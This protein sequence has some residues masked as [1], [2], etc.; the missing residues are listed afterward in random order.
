MSAAEVQRLF[1]VAHDGC[2]ILQADGG[3]RSSRTSWHCPCGQHRN[4][5]RTP[6]LLIRPAKNERYGS[7]I[8]QG[9]SPTCAFHGDPKDVFDAFNVYRILHGLSNA[10]MLLHA[11][12][13]LGLPEH[14]PATQRDDTGQPDHHA[15]RR[16]V[17]PAETPAASP[18]QPAISAAAVL[19]RAGEDCSLSRAMRTLL[20][21]VV[22]LLGTRPA[23]QITLRTLV[24]KTGLTRRTIQI[25]QRRLVEDGYLTITPTSKRC[26]G[27]DANRYALCMGGGA[28]KTIAP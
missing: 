15:R 3:R 27:D 5:D 13:E 7:H 24:D 11:R 25:A 16:S 22:S 18:P 23:T 26:G 4:G 12:R 21:I 17:Q 10:E 14:A 6:S 8:V 28:I 20:A 2:D 19:A 9:Y 1:N